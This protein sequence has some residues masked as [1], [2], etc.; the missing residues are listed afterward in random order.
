MENKLKEA[1]GNLK[2]Y[3]DSVEKFKSAVTFALPDEGHGS[4]LTDSALWALS[5]YATS[6][7]GVM[8][9]FNFRETALLDIKIM[10]PDTQKEWASSAPQIKEV[11]I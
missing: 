8:E 9:P 6:D 1:L 10:T 5:E 4:R 7:T 2:C 3:S 11:C